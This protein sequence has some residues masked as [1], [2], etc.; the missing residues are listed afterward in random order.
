MTGWLLGM[1]FLLIAGGVVLFVASVYRPAP[2]GRAIT[3]GDGPDSTSEATDITALGEAAQAAR[4]QFVDKRDPSRVAGELSF[5]RSDPQAGGLLGLTQPRAWIYLR[6]GRVMHVRA[7][8]GAVK[9]PSPQQQ[10]EAGDFSGHVVVRMFNKREDPSAPAID[11]DRDPAALLATMP[12][13]RFDT[14]LLELSTR[15]PF[16][17]STNELEFRGTGLMVRGNQVQD[18]LEYLKV[19]TSQ[20]I[21]YRVTPRGERTRPV[22]PPPTTTQPPHSL[23][24]TVATGTSA[25]PAH[26]GAPAPHANEPALPA[27]EASTPI[28]ALKEVLYKAVFADNV[29]VTQAGRRLT[30][31]VLSVWVRML[32]NKLPEGAF[33]SAGKDS[34]AVAESAPR[35]DALSLTARIVA[36]A[37]GAIQPEP[38]T[39]PEALPV[40]MFVSGPTDLKMVWSG[41]LTMAPL[42]S[43]PVPEELAS[44]NSFAARFE[45]MKSA[46]VD[47]SDSETSTVGVA[48]SVAYFATTRWSEISGG[49]KVP[50]AVVFA[51]G[52]GRIVGPKVRVNLGTGNATVPGAGLLASYQRAAKIAPTAPTPPAPSGA[53]LPADQIRQVTWSDQ[54][55]FKLRTRDGT[56][57][58]EIEWAQFSGTVEA[59]DRLSFLAGDSLRAE[60]I[61]TPEQPSSLAKVTGRG[62]VLAVAGARRI[63]PNL[64][65][66]AQD[67]FV[68]GDSLEVSFKPS[69]AKAGD[70]DPTFALATGN[71]RA[72]NRDAEIRAQRFEVGLTR[73]DKNR[74]AA[75]NLQATGSVVFTR[76]DGIAAR[77]D[78]LKADAT[79]KTAELTGRSVA[80][81]RGASKILG[82][83]MRMEEDEGRL[84]VFGP[85]SFL[86]DQES[87][88]D[89]KTG[90][91]TKVR[92]TW[93]KSMAFNNAKGTLEAVGE[94]EV[95]ALGPL[96]LQIA[97]ADR[98]RLNLTP[99]SSSA[100]GAKGEPDRRKLL[101]AEIEG[102]VL[103]SDGTARA[104]VE[105]R[106]YRPSTTPGDSRRVLE[107]VLFLE[108]D[109][110]VADDVAGTV[111]VPGDGRAVILDQKTEEASEQSP[112]PK[113]S[114]G[115]PPR[116][117]SRFVWQ[118]S[119]RYTRESGLIQLDKQVELTHKAAGAT[120]A[121]RMVCSRLDATINAPDAGTAQ[122]QGQV[123]RTGEG[124]TR[125]TQAIAI[126]Q[127][128]AESGPNR[129]TADRF[130]YDA[131][132]GRGTAI[133]DDGNRVTLYDDRRAAP[134]VAKRL[135]WDIVGDRVEVSSPAPMALPR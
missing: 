129:M 94:S 73:D 76:R 111:D 3:A 17:I 91:P 135:L 51:P 50:N 44:G 38:D 113:A 98:L 123:L 56:V 5:D 127:V 67:S 87:G 7:D 103:T 122:G 13:V 29:V 120:V 40:T 78:E 1:A 71:V 74:V 131:T 11:P 118:G 57:V 97:R 54:A 2:R 36:M 15:E 47:L 28:L 23:M 39:A 107:Q 84:L 79:G 62:N 80:V 16:I 30:A 58:G 104:S 66:P 18:R 27:P 46:Q 55:D 9:M 105:S 108:G 102:S 112:T 110:I 88:E 42:P 52:I 96:S 93:T 130:E 75:S 6:D 4:L 116:G 82:T 126:G 117:T 34:G 48:Q 37:M 64:V 125:L 20:W 115:T 21:T 92:A 86:H 65:G 132:L 45:A 72:A 14:A 95:R 90:E 22:P 106:R 114:P 61:R 109:R 81:S 85:G 99:A 121:A 133:A 43:G 83:Q 41:P 49:S 77:A 134:W 31:D 24:P 12:S 63:D 60:F 35:T 8:T 59:R 69:T 26:T 70:V 68:V 19:D 100:T 128:Y 124:A 32:D 101:R 89:A 10:P 53:D 119:M 25:N 33:A